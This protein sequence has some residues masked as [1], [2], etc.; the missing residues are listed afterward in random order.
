AAE[1]AATPTTSADQRNPT[2]AA[3]PGSYAT[4]WESTGQDGS[5][6][7]IFGRLEAT[8]GNGMTEPGEFCDDGNLTNGD[9]CESTCTPTGCGDG[10]VTGSEDCDDGNITS[11][12]CCSGG[13]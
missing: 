13:C 11:G 4:V 10:N 2:V 12:D 9:G 8:C 5:G 7:G 3:S 6:G 1:K